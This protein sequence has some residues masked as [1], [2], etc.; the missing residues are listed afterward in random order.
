MP[1]FDSSSPLQPD[2]STERRFSLGPRLRS[3]RL[4]AFAVA[5]CLGATGCVSKQAAREH[6]RQ[7]YEAGFKQG[8]LNEQLKRTHVFFRGPVQQ[9]TL[10]WHQGLTLAQAIAEAVYVAPHDPSAITL[11]RG[12]R[13]IPVD[14][15]ELFRGV[16]PPL[17]AGD[18]IELR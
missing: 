13:V 14:P 16:D 5:G 15:A 1:N 12:G 6:S 17:E 7:A 11:T 2:R 4:L 3:S 8:Q 9:Q 10:R 18:L